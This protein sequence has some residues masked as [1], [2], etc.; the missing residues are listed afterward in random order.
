MADL[1]ADLY[2]GLELEPRLPSAVELAGKLSTVVA[3]RETLEA[4]LRALQAEDLQ[5]REAIKDLTRRTCVLLAT[6]RLEL[7]RKDAQIDDLAAPHRR[8]SPAK[9]PR[10]ASPAAAAASPPPAA[11][12]GRPP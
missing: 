8:R 10:L 3:E 5:L 12:S 4:E 2:G 1:D 9:Q 7:K 6:A 11:A